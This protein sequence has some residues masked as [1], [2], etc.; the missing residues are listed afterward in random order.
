[1][2]KPPTDRPRP[3]PDSLCHSCAAPPKYVE[4][5]NATFILCPLLPNRYPP[6]PVKS[7]ELYVAKT[8]ERGTR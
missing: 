1:M 2:A 8:I 6:Q 3:F 7:C 5:R 4:G